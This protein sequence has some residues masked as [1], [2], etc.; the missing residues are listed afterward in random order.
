MVPEPDVVPPP[1]LQDFSDALPHDLPVGGRLRQFWRQWKSMGASRKV[2]RWLRFG[3]PLPFHKDQRGLQISPPLKLYPPPEL[4]TCY[5]DPVKQSQLLSMLDELVQKRAIR[6]IAHDIPVHFSRVFLVPKK[7]GKQRLVVDLSNLNEWLLCPKF[8]MDHA[9]VIRGS[10]TPHMWATSIDLADAYLHI[11]MIEGNWKFLVFQV[12]DRRY[13]F[14]VLPFGLNT[15]P[16]VFSEVMKALKR[17][18]RALGLILFQYLDDWL[19][20]NIDMALLTHQTVNLLQ[21]AAR[22][23]LLINHAKSEVVPKQTIVFLGDMLD[24]VQGMVFPTQVRFSAIC[25]K[26]SLITKHQDATFMHV[27]S[28]LGLLAATEKIVPYGRLHFRSLQAFCGFHMSHKVKRFQKVVLPNHVLLDLLWWTDTTNVLRGLPM[29]APVP[30]IQIQTDAS[31]TGWGISYQ[32]RIISG[33]WD[34]EDRL[35]H[36]NLLEMKTVLIACDRL[37]TQL[38]DKCVLFLIDN[39]TVVSYLRKQGGHARKR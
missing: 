11:P 19:Q 22:L 37:A 17:W 18:G 3:Y 16:S 8:K 35:L 14:M 2:V 34:A 5:A 36:I 15:A 29:T 39:S 26:V 9:Q 7:N 4:V 31:T 27:H 25:G 20:L 13:Q 6:E 1:T 28:L 24:F 32:N 23:G 38:Q 33:L 21:Q 30:D 10:L 12:G